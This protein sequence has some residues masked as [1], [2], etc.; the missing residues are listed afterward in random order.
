MIL[1]VQFLNDFKNY[2]N[3]ILLIKFRL[4]PEIPL[5]LVSEDFKNS[6]IN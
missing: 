4:I 1:F 2:N 6:V 5:N 3:K